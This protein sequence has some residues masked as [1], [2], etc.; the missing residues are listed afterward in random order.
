MNS[1]AAQIGGTDCHDVGTSHV[2][3]LPLYLANSGVH[4]RVRTNALI[5]PHFLPSEAPCGNAIRPDCRRNDE[6]FR[7]VNQQRRKCIPRA[8]DD[9]LFAQ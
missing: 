7:V 9:R 3:R 8:F 4:G 5:V 6:P 2:L 1:V